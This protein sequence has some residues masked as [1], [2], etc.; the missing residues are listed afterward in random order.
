MTQCQNKLSLISN[1]VLKPMKLINEKIFFYRKYLGLFILIWSSL[2]FLNI[3]WSR[4]INSYN[5][6]YLSVANLDFFERFRVDSG[7]SQEFGFYLI[8]N[9]FSGHISFP[10]Y[11][12]FLIFSSLLLKF[13]ALLKLNSAPQVFDVLPY[14][15]LLGFLHE[16]AQLRIAL[17]LSIVLWAIV[18]WARNNLWESLLLFLLAITFHSSVIIFL[19]PIA[20]LFFLASKPKILYVCLALLILA[21]SIIPF[22][23][24]AAFAT[25]VIPRYSLYFMPQVLSTQNSSGLFQYYFIFFGLL[26]CFIWHYFKPTTFIWQNLKTFSLVSGILAVGILQSLSFSVV[27]ASR[28]ADQMLLP[29]SLVLGACLTQL[30]L[31]RK[32]FPLVMMILILLVYGIL[33]GYLSFRTIAHPLHN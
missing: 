23:Y 27:I 8:Q 26:V 29:I 33:R 5:Q 30:R 16:G 3:N 14:L 11:I 17:A 13:F 22:Q 4:D 12:A 9:L 2:F 15:L 32:I 25:E 28:F 10:G 1:L 19:I 18:M 7:F 6:F 20:T 21:T 24:V 31:Q